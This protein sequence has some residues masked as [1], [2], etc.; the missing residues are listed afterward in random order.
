[1]KQYD[2]FIIGFGK[3]GKTVAA[4]L[5]NRGWKVALIERSEKMYGG[6][7][8]NTGCIPSKA[9][10]HE[11]QTADTLFKD[12]FKKQ[13]EFYKHAVA[14]K[15]KMT[16][17]LRETNFNFLSNHP[18]VTV[19]NGSA[20]FISPTEIKV[21]L[22]DEELTLQ[23]KEVFINTG[24]TPIIPAIEGV[25]DSKHVYTSTTLLNLDILPQ[26]L[27]IVGAGTIGL[28][29]ASMYAGF[30]S[31][32][33]VLEGGHKFLPNQDVDI[34]DKVREVLETKGIEFRLNTRIQ[35]VTDKAD[36]VTLAYTDAVDG[37]P[38]F[39]DADAILL[40][41]GRK[42]TI[43]SLNL[44]EAGV[45]VDSRGAIVVDEHLRTSTPNIWAM[46][47]VKGG[48]QFTYLSLDDCRIICDQ[49]FGKRVRTTADR[50]PVPYSLF[51]DPPLS[52]IGLTEKEAIKRGYLIK[53]SQIPAL[54]VVRTRTL[55][56]TAGVLKAVID[57]QTGRILGCT[58][59]CAGA[60]E[61]INIVNVAMKTGQHYQFLRDFIFTHPRKSEGLNELF[62][63][64]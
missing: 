5:S 29:C 18:N 17:F 45:K 49:L 55:Q 37:T 52:H 40:A 54:S 62:T 56:K 28:E 25:R 20:F 4:K 2:A 11:A 6:A 57:A 33:T 63:I 38:H 61:I 15:D 9:L 22:T 35:S 31:K 53:V 23:G 60:P 39:V 24:S 14:R 16:A 10:I 51:I 19:Y 30:G 21:V 3:G 48:S 50:N 58:L 47:D 1:M 12:H 8:I 13:A 32:V 34:A 43:D 59:F 64:E 26:H 7:C 41:V 42:P 27:L 44:Q 46:G 36:G